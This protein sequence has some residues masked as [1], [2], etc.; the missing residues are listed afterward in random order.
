MTYIK[1]C[2]KI[3]QLA[4][5]L[6]KVRWAGAG[7]FSARCPLC[8]SGLHKGDRR[9]NVSQID[10]KDPESNIRGEC[11]NCHE[12]V[13]T[14]AQ[15]FGF[16]WAMETEEEKEKK[17][18]AFMSHFEWVGENRCTVCQ[19]F[20]RLNMFQLMY[21]CAKK[22]L[23]RKGELSEIDSKCRDF[24]MN[25]PLVRHDIASFDESINSHEGFIRVLQQRKQ[26]LEVIL[27]ESKPVI[28]DGFE[29]K[30]KAPQGEAREE[31]TV[32]K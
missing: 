13:K 25:E 3:A 23:Y 21:G 19:H 30:E 15:S 11:A 26:F 24:E 9:L 5:K 7:E 4:E 28:A 31:V 2:K 1:Q 29:Q 14:I 22:N 18:E 12:G 16:E 27:R 10:K 6:E 20:E 17:K 8:G 32:G